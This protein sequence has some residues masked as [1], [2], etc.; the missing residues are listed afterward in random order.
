MIILRELPPNGM[1]ISRRRVAPRAEAGQA[2]LPHR[3]TIGRTTY[4]QV[5]STNRRNASARPLNPRRGRRSAAICPVACAIP[6]PKNVTYY[7]DYGQLVGHVLRMRWLGGPRLSLPA[8]A[9]PVSCAA[10]P[11]NR[12]AAG[13][14]CGAFPRRFGLG[15]CG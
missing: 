12:R 5:Y 10:Q 1:R 15:F 2:R 3:Y 7:V 8:A 11:P 9:R 4:R 14:A 13:K 6:S